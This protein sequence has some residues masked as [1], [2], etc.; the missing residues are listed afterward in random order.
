[1]GDRSHH[2][3]LDLAIAM[4]SGGRD[5]VHMSEI[6]TRIGIPCKLAGSAGSVRYWVERNNYRAIEHLAE[7]DVISAGLLLASYLDVQGE[8]LSAKAAQL[9]I[10][11]SVRPLRAHAPYAR[12]LGNVADRLRREIHEELNRWMARVA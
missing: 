9:A 6:A 12:I 1:M 7:S 3:H 2:V 10:I 8:L 11:R 5:F 4:K